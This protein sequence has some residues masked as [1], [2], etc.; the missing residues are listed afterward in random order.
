MP[1]TEILFVIA[2]ILIVVDFFITN[3]ITTHVAYVI[4]C[5]NVM[6]LFDIPILYKIL[7]GLLFWFVLVA[8]H[9]IAWRRLV[10]R[11]TNR[12][13]APDKHVDGP[14]GRIGLQGTIK[15]Q[16]GKTLASIQG[17]LWNV[18]AE[19]NNPLSDG[20]KI[21]VTDEKDGTLIVRAS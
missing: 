3:D 21:V 6:R 1:L 10:L 11:F 8:F 5:V 20:D 19:N 12:F 7:F 16:D 13:I 17:D 15:S 9:Y 14:R 18:E 4:I 2:A